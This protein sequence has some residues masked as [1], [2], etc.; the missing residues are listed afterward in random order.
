LSQSQVKKRKEYLI[1]L[2]QPCKNV[3]EFL[4]KIKTLDCSI[5]KYWGE[6]LINKQIPFIKNIQWQIN[7]NKLDLPDIIIERQETKPKNM[8]IHKGGRKMVFDGP[9]P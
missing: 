4:A 5:Y 6:E 1:N 9:P 8:K 3:K 7:T 2:Y